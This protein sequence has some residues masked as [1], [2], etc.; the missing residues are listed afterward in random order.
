MNSER[1]LERR[2]GGQIIGAQPREWLDVAARVT[3]TAEIAAR[4]SD[5]HLYF[6][7]D[8]KS[9][10]LSMGDLF[11]AEAGMHR[12]NTKSRLGGAQTMKYQVILTPDETGGFVVE[13]PSVPGCI[14]EGDTEAEALENIR[15]AIRGCIAARREL[16]LPLGVEVREVEV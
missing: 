6:A 5:G 4:S 14:S 2:S 3:V 12:L 15:E 13:C 1:I 10:D 9:R 16:G 11:S 8:S 7:S